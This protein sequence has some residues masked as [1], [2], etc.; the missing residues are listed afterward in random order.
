[1]RIELRGS[2]VDIS[3]IEPGP[4]ESKFRDNVAEHTH[5]YLDFE[6]SPHSKAYKRMHSQFQAS[7]RP[8]PFTKPPEAVVAKIIHALESRRPKPRYFVT[9]P[10]HVFGFLRRILPSRGLDFIMR[11]VHKRER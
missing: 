6:H 1:M 10:T 9:T 3:L 2:G 5:A 7:S 11:Q 4:I 8:I